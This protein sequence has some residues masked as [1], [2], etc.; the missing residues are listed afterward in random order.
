MDHF[1][2]LLD[3]PGNA[4]SR[5]QIAKLGEFTD[6]R[7]GDFAITK[8]DVKAWKENLKHL[9][10]ERALI[11]LDHAADRSPRRTEAAGWIT[12]VELDGD[13][14]VATVEWTPVGEKAV[15]EGRYLFF[16]P[17]YGPHVDEHG[18]KFENT[19]V[20]GALTNKPFLNMPTVQLAADESLR[21]ALT[22]DTGVQALA[23]AED[24]GVTP[25]PS[26]SRPQMT[27][28]DDTLIKTL[29][30]GEDADT[31]AAVSRINELKARI[32]ELEAPPSDTKTLE[33]QAKDA[34]KILLDEATL[35]TLQQNA[36]AGK[37]AAE[38]LKG[39]KFDTSFTRA[40]EAGKAVPAEREN[41]ERLY[42]LDNDTVLSMLSDREP[43]VNV[44]PQGSTQAV[45]KGDVPEGYDPAG[46]E[47]DQ[48]VRD[49]LKELGKPLSEY[50]DVH[51]ELLTGGDL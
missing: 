32:V 3:A 48:K 15:S 25:Q 2:V 27:S 44:T 10:G 17:T 49:R 30:L 19:L 36:D 13:K 35:A 8:D 4:A 16:S 31:D 42:Q 34:G 5:V 51:K 22:L 47:L 12:D 11:D 33:A 46:Y 23:R 26:D 18:T 37:E 14:P 24:F 50:P 6:K 40:L 9:P 39:M 21:E 1:T 29:D 7:Y 20:G 28:L 45:Q 43:V 41:L 38:Q